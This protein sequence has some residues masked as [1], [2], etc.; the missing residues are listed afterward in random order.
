MKVIRI[1]LSDLKNF[2]FQR[3][4]IFMILFIGLIVASYSLS[5]FVA[6]NMHVIDMVDNFFNYSTKYYIGGNGHSISNEN[7]NKLYSWLKE[8]GLDNSKINIYSE[9]MLIDG[10]DDHNHSEIIIIQG[11]NNTNSNRI[12]FVGRTMDNTDLTQK[13]NYILI[14]YYSEM[15]QES[16]YSIN[17]EIGISGKKYIISA[18]DKIQL[19]NRIYEDCNTN[20][21]YT[22]DYETHLNPVAIPYTTFLM[23]DYDIYGI[24][25]IFNSPL[26]SDQ[27]D[28]F[29]QILEQFFGNNTIIKPLTTGNHSIK[30]IKEELIKYSII[31]LLALI[32]IMALFS[33]WID[34][35][36]RK[37]MIYRLCGAKNSIIY[38]II[39]LE[40]L[41]IALITTS[42]GIVLYYL[43]IPLLQKIYIS[44][45]LSFTEIISIQGII[46]LLI[47]VLINLNI[48]KIFTRNTRYIRRR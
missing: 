2:I 3:K 28:S 16:I 31:I 4:Y 40:A 47:F 11:T 12:D 42:L 9:M 14:D 37:Y 24:E 30:D 34:K 48:I 7:F 21:Y 5:F 13:S 32:N 36:W 1:V 19:N 45:T 22:N 8:N 44:Y 33:Y 20:Q 18:I 38:S 15:A 29:E 35:N 39:I 46:L 17:K 6:Q 41:F 25:I 10:I 27:R 26:T 43:S 23:N